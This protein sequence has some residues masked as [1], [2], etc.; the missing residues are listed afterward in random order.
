MANDADLVRLT[1]DGQIFLGPYGADVPTSHEYTPSG[2]YTD[3]G[4]YSE[5]GFTLTPEPGDN[6]S[7]KAHNSQVVVDE[8]EPGN[9]TVQFSGIQD[10][11]TVTEAYF[12]T[13]VD[14]SD[15]SITLTRASVQTYRS[16]VTIGLT[17]NG[18]TVLGHYPR[19]KVRDREAVTFNPTTLQAYGMT[20][21]T[22]L[23]T[24]ETSAYH[25]KAWHSALIVAGS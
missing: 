20:L 15:G 5:D 8:D 11:V 4:F 24:E 19:V 23:D 17:G 2:D 13:T 21:R 1:K 9:W 25:L 16:L 14:T 18:D 10:G 12:D 7:I 22:F 3:I 6:T